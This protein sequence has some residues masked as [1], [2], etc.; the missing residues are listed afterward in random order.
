MNMNDLLE[1]PEISYR[2]KLIDIRNIE[3]ERFLYSGVPKEIILAILCNMGGRDVRLLV[4]ELLAEL[5]KVAT[6][7]D[8][9]R[10][11]RQLEMLSRLRDIQRIVLEEVKKMPITA[12]DL[13]LETDLRF[14]QGRQEGRQEGRVEGEQKG[15]VEGRVEGLHDAIEV[16]LMS[17]FGEAGLSLM[18]KIRGYGDQSRL[19]AITEV[20][21]KA[22]DIR[23]V[24]GLL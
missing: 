22:E 5:M 1:M 8:L 24:E 17:K 6:G 20:L 10:Y 23:E 21:A 9:S 13:P 2:Y 18:P 12:Y 3:C 19:R 14:I 16:L 15:R 4:R 11:V 7:L